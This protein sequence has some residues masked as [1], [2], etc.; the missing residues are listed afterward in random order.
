MDMIDELG[1]CNW[2]PGVPAMLTQQLRVELHVFY[3]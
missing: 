3:Q 2:R 1:V